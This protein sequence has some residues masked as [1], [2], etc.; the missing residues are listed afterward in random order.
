MC[1]KCGAFLWFIGVGGWRGECGYTWPKPF[2]AEK[3]EC[4][5]QEVTDV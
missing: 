1:P 2:F 3:N 5:G 4:N